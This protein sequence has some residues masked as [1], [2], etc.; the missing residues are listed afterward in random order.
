MFS[1]W[2]IGLLFVWQIGLICCCCLA[3][4]CLCGGSLCFSAWFFHL[5][6]LQIYYIR[7]SS[8]S[9]YSTSSLISWTNYASFRAH[10]SSSGALD[11]PTSSASLPCPAKC[12]LRFLGSCAVCSSWLGSRRRRIRIGFL[13]GYRRSF[14]IWRRQ[15]SCCPIP[16]C[17]IVFLCCR[18]F[19]FSDRTQDF[20]ANCKSSAHLFRPFST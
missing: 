6:F 10:W 1:N 18:V 12:S 15:M 5:I 16:W 7:Q 14:W 13:F 11:S 19:W 2:M 20:I 9:I 17:S 8:Y 4:R 3:K